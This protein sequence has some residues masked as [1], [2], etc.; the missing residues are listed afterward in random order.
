MCVLAKVLD[1]RHPG[2]RDWTSLARSLGVEHLLR[3][4]AAADTA[5]PGPALSRLDAVLDAWSTETDATV[6]DL[7]RQL[8][9]LGRTDAVE[10]LL[11][12]APL[13]KYV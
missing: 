1:R 9:R 5:D 4:P 12:L 13:Y 11:S 3:A 8:V 7:H 2:G 6:R 10:A